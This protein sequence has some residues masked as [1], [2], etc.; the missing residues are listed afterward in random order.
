MK[1]LL[2]ITTVF[3]LSLTL[4][5]ATAQDHPKKASKDKAG[6]CAGHAKS[7]CGEKS[8][9]ACGEEVSKKN[10]DKHVCG[11]ECKD[12]CTHAEK[13]QTTEKK[14]DKKS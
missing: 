5:V 12:K 13:A 4:S 6:C 7:S 14:E 2:A 1:K 9:A 3:L 10:T 8:K 11:D